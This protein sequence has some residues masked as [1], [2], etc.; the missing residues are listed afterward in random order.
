DSEPADAIACRTAQL[1]AAATPGIRAGSPTSTAVTCRP[2]EASRRA[3][4]NPSPPL[5][6]GP[7]SRTVSGAGASGPPG[8]PIGSAR[9]ASSERDLGNRGAGALHQRVG[10][11]TKALGRLIDARHL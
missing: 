11:E 5:L 7:H 6:P 9:L 10:R 3:A 4:T 8:P 2:A 1:C